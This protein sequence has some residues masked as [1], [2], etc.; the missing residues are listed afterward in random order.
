MLQYIRWGK[1]VLNE[2]KQSV[3][4]IHSQLLCELGFGLLL[5]LPNIL[6]WLHF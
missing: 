4:L 2:S 1:S 5:S 6:T 3:N